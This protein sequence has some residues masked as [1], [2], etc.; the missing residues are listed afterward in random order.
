M[1]GRNF[2]RF[3]ETIAGIK[4]VSLETCDNSVGIGMGGEGEG[5]RVEG[6]TTK[7]EVE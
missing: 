2:G 6:P 3:Q 4:S 7:L 5:V 1:G